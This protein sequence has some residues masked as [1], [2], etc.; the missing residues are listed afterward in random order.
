MV[1]VSRVSYDFVAPLDV[2]EFVERM[3]INLTH[4]FGQNV[5]QMILDPYWTNVVNEN[6]YS[7]DLPLLR[8]NNIVFPRNAM[9]YT[10]GAV[11]YLW[12]AMENIQRGRHYD[13]SA[14][15]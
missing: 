1:Q 3:N 9:V 15:I 6:I 10:H 7:S 2:E 11:R 5:W 13:H 8:K 4:Y 14:W 12:P